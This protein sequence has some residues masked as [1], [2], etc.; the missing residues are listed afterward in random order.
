[1][2][3]V[4]QNI[5]IEYRA[6]KYKTLKMKIFFKLLKFKQVIKYMYNYI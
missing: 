3:N 2:Y 4:T 6:Q 1:M 5:E